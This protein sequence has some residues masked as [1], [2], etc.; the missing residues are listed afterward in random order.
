MLTQQNTFVRFRNFRRL[1]KTPFIIYVDFEGVL[2]SSTSDNDDGP[3]TKKYQDNV[4][5][6][7]CKLKCLW[8][9]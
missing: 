6:Y 2:Q 1:L 4:C 7:G 9:M 8:T 5:S 3:N